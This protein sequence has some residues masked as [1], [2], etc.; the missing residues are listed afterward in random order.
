MIIYLQ[1]LFKSV[2]NIPNFINYYDY[3]NFSNW[4]KRNCK[5]LKHLY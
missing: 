2:L 3:T 4:I 5:I 1:Y